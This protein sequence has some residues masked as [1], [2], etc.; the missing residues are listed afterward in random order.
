M[1]Q[2]YYND[3]REF[4]TSETKR[5]G[6][7]KKLIAEYLP[8]L[9]E[10]LSTYHIVIFNIYRFASA[11][12]HALLLLGYAVYIIDHDGGQLAIDGLAY[13]AFAHNPIPLSPSSLS[14][15]DPLDAIFKNIYDQHKWYTLFA[16][17]I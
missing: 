1:K 17:I 5:C 3:Y 6:D 11:A 15:N 14:K 12:F 8:Q 2:K 4:F 9:C 13:L 10:G 16:N 7:V